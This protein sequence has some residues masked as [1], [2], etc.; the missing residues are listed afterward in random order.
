MLRR[1][2]IAY[3]FVILSA[4]ILVYAFSGCKDRHE[5]TEDLSEYVGDIEIEV[6]LGN[7]DDLRDM[8]R[9]DI[10]FT[11]RNKGDKTIK[12]LL[13]EV[14]FYDSD[15]S[16]V[17]RTKSILISVNPNMESIAEEEKKTRWC[18]LP[19]GEI[20]STGY[21]VVYF[22]GGEPDLRE[23]VKTQWDNLTASV[24]VKKLI[25]E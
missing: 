3:V 7:R 17:G 13:G 15:G 24:L 9:D 4:L 23:K 10:I 21:D 16:E 22:F 1:S 14:V 11:V 20:I 2:H 19:P 25:A 12:E 18:S 8:D 6:E 5:V